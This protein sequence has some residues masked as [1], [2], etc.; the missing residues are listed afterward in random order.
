MTP[1][2]S[3]TGAGVGDCAMGGRSSPGEI[4]IINAA[5]TH[6]WMEIDRQIW[7]P[8]PEPEPPNLTN[9]TS[10]NQNPMDTSYPGIR[11]QPVLQLSFLLTTAENHWDRDKYYSSCILQTVFQSK[12]FVTRTRTHKNLLHL[13]F[14]IM[15]DNLI[16]KLVLFMQYLSQIITYLCNNPLQIAPYHSNPLLFIVLAKGI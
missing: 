11:W 9:R 1:H 14:P 8:A 5:Q 12:Y 16:K 3:D 2:T 10:L 13:I 6:A 15:L 4:Y 7:C